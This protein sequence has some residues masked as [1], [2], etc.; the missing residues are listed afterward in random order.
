MLGG[1]LAFHLQRSQALLNLKGSFEHSKKL[2]LPDVCQ[3]SC[4]CSA[5]PLLCYFFP[6]TIIKQLPLLR[7]INGL[8]SQH[9]DWA[10][11][12]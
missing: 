4:N 5:F 8:K 2:L 11:E 6:G 3:I 1:C 7:L 12:S 10:L 9:Q